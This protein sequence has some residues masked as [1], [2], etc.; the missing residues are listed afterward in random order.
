MPIEV[1]SELFNVLHLP[2]SG[3]LILSGQPAKTGQL[4]HALAAYRR[5]GAKL[6][7]SL[8]PAHE[9]ALL[10]LESLQ[11]RCASFGLAWARCPIE[12]FAP[13]GPEFEHVWR[14]ISPD[15]HARLDAGQGVALHCRA[16]L[17]RT[18]TVAARILID[19]GLTVDQAIQ[20][21]RQ[22][23]TGAIETA[24]QEAYLHQ[25]TPKPDLVPKYGV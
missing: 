19:R 13:P 12:D 2:A 7:V 1:E 10:G 22:A 6:L 8:L 23:R 18:G 15:L 4:D 20:Q 11:Q 24:A 16:G 3:L 14:Q 5:S 25:L 9:M 17:G 21:V